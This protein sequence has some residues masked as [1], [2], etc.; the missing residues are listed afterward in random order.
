[1]DYKDTLNLPSTTFSMKANLK[2]KEPEILK[3]WE[4][5]DIYKYVQQTRKDSEMFLLH[6]GPPYANGHIHMGHALNKVLKDIVI[7]YKTLRGYNSPY[8]PGWDTHGL[9]IEHKVTTELGEKAKQ[10]SKN[11]IR[12]LC[13]EYA[14][15]HVQIQKEEFKRLGVRG[16][17]DEA[18]VTLDPVYESQVLDVFNSF[19]KQGNVYRKKKPIYWCAECQT[20]LAEAEVEYHDHS[21]SSIYVKFEFDVN[22]YIVIWTTTPWTLPANVAIAVHPEYDYC[23]VKVGNEYWILAKQLVP[24]VMKDAKIDSYEITEVFKGASLE[25]KSAKHPFIERQSLIVLADYV[26]LEDGS[27]CVHTAP[28]HGADDY[29]TGLKYNL[30]VLSPVNHEGIFTKEAGKYEGLKIW[31]ANEVIINDL[32]ASNHLIASQK[33]THSY[34]HCWRCKSPIIFRATEQWFISVENNSLRQKVLNEIKNV[35]WIPEWGETRITSMIHDRPDWCISRQRAWG[36]PIPALYCE[37]CTEVLLDPQV[38]EKFIS[39]V[40]AKGTNAWYDMDLKELLPDGFKCPKCGS[41]HLRKQYDILDVWIDS[42]ASFQAVIHAR[43]ELKKFPAD[44]YLEGSDQHRGWFQSSIFMSVGKHGKAP[45]RKVLTHGFIKD[46]EGKKMSKSIGNVIAPQEIIDRYG[47]DVLRLWVASSDYRG[48][49]SISYK[50]LDQQVDVYRKFRNTVRFLL[51][52]IS[53]FDPKKDLVKYEEM[54]ELDRWAMMKLH[55]LIRDVTQAYES[56]EFYRVHQ[57]LNN[58]CTVSMSS[59]YLDIIKDR[60]YTL[61]KKSQ[62][63]RSAQSV[64]YEILM[65][66][67]KMMAPIITFTTEEIYDHLSENFEKKATVQAESW[68]EFNENYIDKAL[69]EKWNRVLLIREDILK[70][71]EEKRRDKFIGHSLE[72]KVTV[73]PKE[74]SDCAILDSL[75]NE[76]MSDVIIA[77]GFETGTVENGYEGSLCR[78]RVEKASG[79]KCERCWK[80]DEHTGEDPQFPDT[81]P[82]CAHTLKTMNS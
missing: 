30:P 61:S 43:E 78:V 62:M 32:K 68:P 76:F 7:K 38:L 45:Y 6:D 82:R 13:R 21:S 66:M 64:M 40:K 9:P 39:I 46:E 8:V 73:Q 14:L 67:T 11:Q 59:I 77:S 19:V 58:F 33:I 69:E 41:D 47:A 57:M 54:P 16:N 37:N 17:W 50:I 20:A 22:T 48:D 24:K 63:R 55:E 49:I 42:G 65:A 35:Q 27:G 10:L 12:D 26:T 4:G 52:N 51:G 53:D 34:P 2:E 36:I 23:K 15:K 72:S 28:G 44:L 80:I 60:L 25:N 29:T 70:A 31:K 79:K 71:L 5:L 74:P 18:Y 75:G 81:C 3:K 56:Y 1:M